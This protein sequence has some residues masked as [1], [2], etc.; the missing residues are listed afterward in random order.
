MFKSK[1]RRRFLSSFRFVSFFVGE[2]FFVGKMCEKVVCFVVEYSMKK[3]EKK[4]KGRRMNV[5]MKY[6]E[7]GGTKEKETKFENWVL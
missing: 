1:D 2:I 6:E 7:G 3:K 4:N 5:Q